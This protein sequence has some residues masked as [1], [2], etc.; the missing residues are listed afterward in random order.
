[1]NSVQSYVRNSTALLVARLVNLG[2]NLLVAVWVSRALGV[3]AFGSYSAALGLF[4]LFQV[5]TALGFENMIPHELGRQ[6]AARRQMFSHSV[7]IAA[8]AAIML[9]FVMDGIASVFNYTHA[10]V[11]STWIISLALLPT[12][13][14]SVTEAF[15]IAG[16][17]VEYVALINTFEVMGRLLTSVIILAAGGTT[18][19]VLV[20][21][22]VYR[23]IACLAMFKAYFRFAGQSDWHIQGSYLKRFFSQLFTFSL[24]TILAALFWRIDILFLSIFHTEYQLGIY[25][26]AYKLVFIWSIVP[27]C[28][29]S[30]ALPILSRLYAEGSTRFAN[31]IIKSL[32]YLMAVA[33]P[34]ALAIM[35]LG[36]RVIRSIYGADFS[37]SIS[38]LRM[39]GWLLVPLFLNNVLYRVLISGNR[40]SW[41]LRVTLLGLIINI[42]LCL[43]LVPTYGAVGAALANLIAVNASLIANIVLVWRFYV[44]MNIPAALWRFLPAGFIAAGISWAAKPY[45]PWL[46]NGILFG[47]TYVLGVI[48]VRALGP[49]D[50]DLLRQVFQGQASF[51]AVNRFERE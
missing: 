45:I 41:T 25:N 29:M 35:V 21:F 31:V 14:I 47:T 16:G 11:V 8:V 24:I 37:A 32:K 49:I 20:V 5:G 34:L 38:V 48:I 10:T 2:G 18:K 42:L 23:F 13:L 22:T 43:V 26:A 30:V 39:L 27:T 36:D 40:Q 1:M 6:P 7:F 28:Y 19:S 33:L 46:L 12:G 50:S 44:R 9:M 15:F 4:T 3:E 51:S 17:R